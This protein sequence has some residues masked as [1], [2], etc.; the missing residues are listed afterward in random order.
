VAR[1]PHGR[2]R[3]P[4]RRAAGSEDRRPRAGGGPAHRGGDAARQVPAAAAASARRSGAR[5]RTRHPPRHDRGAVAPCAAG[6][7]ALAAAA[8]R[9]ARR[10]A[11]R[12]HARRAPRPGRAPLR[13]CVGGAAGRLPN[14]ADLGRDGPGA[15]RAGVH[16]GRL[17][18]GPGDVQGRHQDAAAV[19]AAGVGGRQHLRR[20]GTVAGSAAPV[21]ARLR[22]HPCAGAA[23]AWGHP[24]G[25]GRRRRAAGHDAAR[26]PHRQ[27]RPRVVPRRARRVRPRR[28]PLPALWRHDRA[29]GGGPARHPRLPRLPAPSTPACGRAWRLPVA[30]R[31]RSP[32]GPDERG[33]APRH[34]RPGA[35]RRHRPLRP[36]QQ[37]LLRHL[38]GD[39]PDRAHHVARPAPGR[40]D[41]RAHGDRLPPSAPRG[42]R[43]WWCGPG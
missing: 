35:L 3:R 32:G 18:E 15:A 9:F 39:R 28:R 2:G 7:P 23:A 14:A 4:G 1:R 25:A 33:A 43:R 26:L 8:R 37:R 29:A 11:G 22:R 31:R 24:R 41:P 17:R 40:A 42:R 19:A 36:H 20:R 27:R 34:P 5:R 38:R 6:A 10:G 21:D 12:R 30:A 13:A 16:G